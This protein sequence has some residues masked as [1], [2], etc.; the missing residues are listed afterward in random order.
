[1]GPP[2][3]SLSRD[4]ASMT[5]V[6]CLGAQDTDTNPQRNVMQCNAQYKLRHAAARLQPQLWVIHDHK[7]I[8]KNPHFPEI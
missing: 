5:K 2:F 8:Y 4:E 3:T 7:F 6:P 1:M